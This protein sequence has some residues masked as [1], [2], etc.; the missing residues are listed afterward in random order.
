MHADGFLAPESAADVHEAYESVGPG[1]QVLVKEVAKAM[2]LGAE[3]YD[4][5]VDADVV[6]TARDAMFASLLKVRIGTSEEFEEWDESYDGEV[7]VL[8]SENVDN[9]VW[10]AGPDDEAVAAT[11][12]D[13]ETAAV[14]TLRRQ[15]YGRIYREIIAE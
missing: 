10:H 13:E 8:G 14:G 11:F 15:A 2:E 12:Q 9:V 7:T 3:E 4:E 6:E 1:A 5:R